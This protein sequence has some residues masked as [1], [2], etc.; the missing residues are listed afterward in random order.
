VWSGRLHGCRSRV[1]FRFP[2]GNQDRLRVRVFRSFQFFQGLGEPNRA[3][4]I[5][6]ESLHHF[7][8]M[9]GSNPF[10]DA[11]KTKDLLE[12]P[13]FRADAAGTEQFSSSTSS[14]CPAASRPLFPQRAQLV[15]LFLA[16]ARITGWRFSFTPSIWRLLGNCMQR[17]RDIVYNGCLYNRDALVLQR[18]LGT[19]AMRW[20]TSRFS[21]L[22]CFFVSWFFLSCSRRPQPKVRLLLNQ[23]NQTAF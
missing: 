20:P 23:S 7:S 21:V 19:T 6:R 12:P 17:F 3:L 2:G 4:Q 5:L 8:F 10:G 9:A 16:P 13:L 14:L 15:H 1:L 11:N 22:T 18:N